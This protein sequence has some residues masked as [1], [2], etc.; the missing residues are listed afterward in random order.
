[1][2]MRSH[3]RKLVVWKQSVRPA[4]RYSTPSVARLARP[5]PFRW[6]ARTVRTRWRPIFLVTGALLIV[7]WMMLPSTMAFVPG[8]L[9]LG[10]SV[11]DARSDTGLFTPP[12]AMV[13]GWLRGNK[14]KHL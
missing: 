2:R 5:R 12:T 9:V 10:L 1:M 6:L 7:M 3:R 11:P 13:R 4:D 14:A 8:M